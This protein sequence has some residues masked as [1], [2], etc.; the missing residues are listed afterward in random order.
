M[1]NNLS[2]SLMAIFNAS[3]AIKSKLDT[4]TISGTSYPAIF[5]GR[6][7][8]ANFQDL[9]KTLLVYRVSTITPHDYNEVVYSVQCRSNSESASEDL[10]K[11]VYDATNRVM[12]THSGLPVY[13]RA[14]VLQAIMETEN[15]WNCPVEIRISNRS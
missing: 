6:L 13:F 5:K 12:A 4:F 3:T 14:S 8:P 15:L 2:N 11:A 10:A 9:N 1:D 7:I